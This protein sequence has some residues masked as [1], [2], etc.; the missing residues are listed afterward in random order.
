M[1]QAEKDFNG[2]EQTLHGMLAGIE[3]LFRYNLY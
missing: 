1:Q 3:K 2:S